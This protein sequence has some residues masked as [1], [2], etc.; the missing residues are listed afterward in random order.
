MGNKRGVIRDERA[1]PDLR[2]WRV[3]G[4]SPLCHAAPVFHSPAAD[5]GD[6]PHQSD[7]SMLPEGSAFYDYN[8]VV[9]KMGVLMRHLPLIAALLSGC[10][11]QQID[12]SFELPMLEYGCKYGDC[13]ENWSTGDF[14]LYAKMEAQEW[15]HGSRDVMG[16]DVPQSHRR[17]PGQYYD[18]SRL[19]MRINDVAAVRPSEI[20]KAEV[21]GHAYSST[22]SANEGAYS[23]F[24]FSTPCLDFSHRAFDLIAK[25]KHKPS[26][27]RVV[28]IILN[29]NT[30][31]RRGG[32][33]FGYGKDTHAM[34]LVDETIYDN[35]YLTNVPFD[36]EYPSHYGRE[37]DNV[38]SPKK[39]R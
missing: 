15:S 19:E 16:Y 30:L 23:Q 20:H 25:S 1:V 4:T 17:A 28:T 14:A 34:L 21:S 26:E 6:A 13:G 7:R 18:V 29:D 32:P 24:P 11:L 5:R 10:S 39:Y 27:M 31:D 9:N 35:G 3:C 22:F 8:P 38:W 12:D 36:Y 2:C 37:I 33:R